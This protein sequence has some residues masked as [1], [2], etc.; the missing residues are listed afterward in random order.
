MPAFGAMYSPHAT[1]RPP[2][3]EN[4]LSTLSDFLSYAPAPMAPPLAALPVGVPWDLFKAELL[5]QYGPSLKSARY[6][7]LRK[8]RHTHP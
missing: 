2:H 7:P 5:E 4:P 3:K 6:A 1:V 8:E